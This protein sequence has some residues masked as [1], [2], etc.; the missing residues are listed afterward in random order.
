MLGVHYIGE[1]AVTCDEEIIVC[2]RLFDINY[3]HKGHNMFAECLHGD[4]GI[5]AQWRQ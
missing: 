5:R 4:S 3:I 1:G 2:C